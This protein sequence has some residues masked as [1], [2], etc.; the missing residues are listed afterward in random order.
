MSQTVKTEEVGS[1]YVE[2]IG[3]ISKTRVT[4]EPGVTILAG[5]NAT[6]RTSLLQALMAVFGSD[7]ASLKGDADEGAVELSIDGEQYSRTLRRKNGSI[8]MDGNPYFDDATL[9]D[10]FAFLLESNEARRAVARGDDLRDI[11]MRPVD[12]DEIEREVR[13]LID[14]RERIESN[15]EKISG[16]EEKIP[17]LDSK[18]EDI[19]SNI[20]S[21]EEI[22]L[23]KREELESIET[24]IDTGGSKKEE[25]D[26]KLGKLNDTRREIESNSGD[27]KTE[28][29]SIEALEQERTEVE[30][31]LEDLDDVPSTRINEIDDEVRRLRGEIK[32]IERSVDTLQTAIQTNEELIDGELDIFDELADSDDGAV[33]DALLEDSEERVC[34]TCG[35][36][37][38]PHQIEE[39]TA[40]LRS[41]RESKMGQRNSLEGEIEDLREEQ[42]ECEQRQQRRANLE[43]RIAS[44]AE[45]ISDREARIEELEDR[46]ES[47]REDLESLKAEVEKLRTENQSEFVELQKEVN[48]LEVDLKQL[49]EERDAVIEEIE[50][51]EE[52]IDRLD[53]LEDERS[54]IQA[55]IEAFRTR[56]DELERDAVD[57]FNEHMETILDLL[58][59]KDLERIWLERTEREVREGRRKVSKTYFELHVVRTTDDG[60]VYEDTVDHLSES[61]REVTSLI[62]ALAGY[63]AHGLHEKIPV[64]LI[65]SV[66]AIDSRRLADVIEYFTSYP[67]YL[68]VALLEEDAAALDDTYPRVSD[69]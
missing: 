53:E 20:E 50:S 39:M 8:V 15:I 58:E 60:S 3:G 52:Q 27:I 21:K 12:T 26:N 30:A 16:L 54:E 40:Q 18:K 36:Q 33:T 11:I 23:D 14:E 19:E 38:S 41:V 64:M 1:L 61:E 65:D 55:E 13:R 10:L 49:E 51:I 25:L 46:Q 59:Y 67:E 32:R 47:L 6:N 29:E 31:E 48:R 63:L 2:N 5:R 35:T 37:I 28:R 66:E 69:I 45:E 43:E 44:I 56:I 17:E 24:N 42:R 68:I 7:Q 4:F 62:F 34:W 9:A 22:L 57:E